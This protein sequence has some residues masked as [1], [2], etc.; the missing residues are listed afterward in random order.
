MAGTVKNESYIEEGLNVPNVDNDFK[1]QKVENPVVLSWADI[2]YNVQAK[3]KTDGKFVKANKT[4]VQ[5]TT[6]FAMP[7]EML[8]LMG[9]SGS[10]K[11]SFL[12]CLGNRV[13]SKKVKGS[14][15][16]NGKHMNLKQ[17][18][19][20]LS[21]VAQEDTLM[22]SLTVFETVMFAARFH[23]GFSL[24]NDKLSV[25][26]E[27]TLHSMGLE[28]A[29]NT[30]VG[31]I[32]RKGLSGGQKR[33]LSIAIELISCPAV[34]L[35]DEPTSGLDSS[36]AFSVV[37]Y[38]KRV[39]LQGNHT[40]IMTIHQPSSEIWDMFDRFMLLSKGY[41]VYYGEARNKTLEYF[42]R[43]GYPCPTNYNPADFVL[44][45]TN[46]DFKENRKSLFPNLN[47]E[48]IE[49]K[50]LNEVYRASEEY[51]KSGKPG[52]NFSMIT[53]GS[54]YYDT[55]KEKTIAGNASSGES[56]D[57]IDTDRSTYISD[58]FYLNKRNMLNNI[59]NPGI[60]WM[61]FGM[62]FMLTLII[63]LMFI[64]IGVSQASINSRISVLFFVA[65]FLVFMS[66]AA[67]PFFLEQ[68]ATFVRE[69]QNGAYNTGAYVIS[70][71]LMA[72]PAILL[73]A[74][75][76]TIFVA[77]IPGL[78]GFGNLFVILYLALF[79][80]ESFM[81]L[82]A[83]IVPHYVVGLLLASGFF[84]FCM[85]FIIGKNKKKF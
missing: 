61:R 32:F 31:D 52:K 81:L 72:Q 62:Y 11:T 73:N 3:V 43:I 83:A 9:T 59:R 2:E 24:T 46:T 26:V 60:F 75:I 29:A 67:L 25:L 41:T 23:Y 84:G 17:Q 34:L 53:S 66:V 16:F 51:K 63:G 50:K 18:R 22:G 14:I 69:S 13:L 37:K 35:L 1:G 6:G 57:E 47:E 38:L 4:I 8:A 19:K 65:S 44:M 71:I 54:N 85:F 28:D 55:N 68:R 49:P 82:L 80:A 56:L 40:I 15:S 76:C 7:G 78:N 79:F 5:P 42:E 45:L 33:R 36:S 70:N 58:F 64:D 30:V 48:N 21:Y 27:N 12:D 39:A 77:L 20:I 74:L 10:G